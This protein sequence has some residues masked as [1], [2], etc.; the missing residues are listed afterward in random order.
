MLRSDLERV[1][2]IFLAKGLPGIVQGSQRAH[3]AATAGGAH[4]YNAPV[5][6]TGA[7]MADG[8]SGSF[9]Q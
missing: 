1:Q 2:R 3:P 8:R 9:Y 7:F 6:K 5:G 4:S